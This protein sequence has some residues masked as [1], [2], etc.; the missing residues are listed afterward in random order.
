MREITN[1]SS[2]YTCPKCRKQGAEISN[3]SSFIRLR[4]DDCGLEWQTY[5]LPERKKIAI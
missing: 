3:K 2:T 5:K 1:V 4:C